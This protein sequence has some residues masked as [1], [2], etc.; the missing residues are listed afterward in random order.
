MKP[1]LIFFFFYYSVG[2]KV[3]NGY[4]QYRFECGSGEG[5]V[6]ISSRRVD[7]GLWHS[8]KLRRS[9]KAAELI[10]DETHRASDVSPGKNEIINLE[11]DVVYFGAEVGALYFFSRVE[12]L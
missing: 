2:N 1:C 7:D 4:V 6:R 12:L 5:V 11:S 9:G 10:L 3:V 8:V